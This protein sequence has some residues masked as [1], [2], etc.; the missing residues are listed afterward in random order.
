MKKIANGAFLDGLFLFSVSDSHKSMPLSAFFK[1][2]VCP[3]Q[4]DKARFFYDSKGQVV[5]L[6]TWVFLS[7]EKAKK[8]LAGEYIIQEE[9][10]KKEDGDELWGLDLI[11]PYGHARKMVA[12]LKKEYADKYGTPRTIHWLR[13]HKPSHRIKGKL[14]G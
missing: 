6:F 2:C 13:L 3:M 7:K 9:D 8:F 14:N 4:H 12:A 11:A 5:G 1:N 10:Y